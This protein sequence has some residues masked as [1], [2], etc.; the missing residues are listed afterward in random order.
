MP[1]ETALSIVMVIADLKH[2]HRRVADGV[3]MRLADAA[4]M[5]NVLLALSQQFHPRESLFKMSIAEFPL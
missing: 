3:W 4:S 1:V 5:L 2:L